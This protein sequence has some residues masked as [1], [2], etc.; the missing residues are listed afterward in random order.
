MLAF[1]CDHQSYGHLREIRDKEKTSRSARRMPDLL[2]Y[3]EKKCVEELKE[4]RKRDNS[5]DKLPASRGSTQKRGV[6]IEACQLE[7]VV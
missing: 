3:T 1:M 7:L 6:K 2:P 5:A 4:T